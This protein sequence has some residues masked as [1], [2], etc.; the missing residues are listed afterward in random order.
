M[1]VFALGAIM[2]AT[3]IASVVCLTAAAAPVVLGVVAPCLLAVVGFAVRNEIKKNSTKIST[4]LAG[5]SGMFQTGKLKIE[6]GPGPSSIARP[7]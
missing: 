6:P 2:L 7:G 5:P 4:N 3:G 1:A